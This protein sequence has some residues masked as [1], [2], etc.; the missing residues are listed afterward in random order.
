MQE[1]AATLNKTANSKIVETKFR[2][3]F[4]MAGRNVESSFK[5]FK[6]SLGRPSTKTDYLTEVVHCKSLGDFINSILR[7]RPI[8]SPPLI[9]LGIDGGGGGDLTS[10]SA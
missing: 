6:I 8:T 7:V 3:N 9:K 5:V 1:L 4:T 10:S 2:K